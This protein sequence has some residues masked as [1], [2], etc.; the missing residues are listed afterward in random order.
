MDKIERLKGV[1]K[2]VD[3]PRRKP[4]KAKSGPN[5]SVSEEKPIESPYL[6]RNRKVALNRGA[7]WR[8]KLMG[9]HNKK[10]RQNILKSYR[11]KAG[12]TQVEMAKRLGFLSKT[13][14]SRFEQGL[15]LIPL[16]K[17]QRIANILKTELDSLFNKSGNRFEVKGGK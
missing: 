6:K 13:S 10:G 3:S 8:K 12:L 1:L 14:Y 4:K 5:K 17:A 11:V 15:V 2:P 9:S 7:S 16:K